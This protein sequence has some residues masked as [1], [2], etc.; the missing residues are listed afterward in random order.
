MPGG[1]LRVPAMHHGRP[2]AGIL[3]VD[4]LNR[5]LAQGLHRTLDLGNWFVGGVLTRGIRYLFPG[6]WQ[7]HIQS[8]SQLG[9]NLASLGQAGLSMW[10]KP[11]PFAQLT[12]QSSTRV[13]ACL[14]CLLEPIKRFIAKL[15]YPDSHAGH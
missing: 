10:V 3:F 5:N 11:V 2:G 4:R 14:R 6:G 13:L 1:S 12:G 15:A 9:Q 8:F 7:G